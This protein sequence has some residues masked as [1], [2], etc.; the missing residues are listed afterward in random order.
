MPR[1]GDYDAPVTDSPR[2]V[3]LV[4]DDASVGRAL[5]RLLRTLGFE[6]RW[7]QTAGAF[8]NALPLLNPACLML[9]AHLPDIE[10]LVLYGQLRRSGVTTGV[11][12]ITADHELAESDAMRRT[13]MACLRKPLDEVTLTEAIARAAERS[14]A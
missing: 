8:L 11:V 10:G 6:V 4:E 2:C 5:E 12:F 9:D 3:V 1:A 7:F 13:G 14:L